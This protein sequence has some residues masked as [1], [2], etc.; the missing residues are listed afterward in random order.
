MRSLTGLAAA[1]LALA[2]CE[3]A[4]V[5]TPP[6]GRYIL[7]EVDGRAVPTPAP[8]P[9][10]C[11]PIWHDGWFDLDPIARQFELYLQQRDSC[12]GA[13]VRETRETGSYLRSDGRLRLETTAPG[14]STRRWTAAE[15]GR[16]VTLRYGDNR[17]LFR[18]P[19]P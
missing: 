16:S 8:Q 19:R 15:S 10:A 12:T 18:Q 13:V 11:R 14:G 6:G 2:G 17:L 1:A 9:P 3:T 5:G 7:T 4:F